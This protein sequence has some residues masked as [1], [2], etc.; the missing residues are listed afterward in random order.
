MRERF[1]KWLLVSGHRPAVAVGILALMTGVVLVPDFTRFAIRNTT[2]LFYISSALVGGNITLITVV[3]AIN[4]VILSQEL[5][6]PGSLR[7]EIEQT[8]DY[9]RGTFDRA[10]PPTE[11]SDFLQQL[12]EQTRE[13]AHSLESLLPDS[14]DGTN[15]RLLDDLPEHCERT[16]DRLESTSNTLSSAVVPLIGSD[17][18]DYIHDC[19]RIQSNY[20]EENHEQLLATLDALHSDLE[21]LNVAHQYFTTAFIKEELAT[22]SRLLV[23]VGTVAVSV[24]IALLYQLTTYSGASPP[25]P[26]LFALTVSTVAVG[27]LPLAILIAFFLRVSTVTQHIAVITPFEA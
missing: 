5:E 25:M 12:L 13:R 1:E 3:V 2:P 7:D 14:A 8:A 27:L 19:Y 6:S 4:Q 20:G 9:R 26:G 10:V 22:L 16:S 23:Y 21:N 18:A 11:P 15:D 24:P 17:Y